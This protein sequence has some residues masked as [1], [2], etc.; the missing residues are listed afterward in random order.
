MKNIIILLFC[1]ICNFTC[2]LSQSK[3]VNEVLKLAPGEGYIYTVNINNLNNLLTP[4]DL[5]KWA[6][7]NSDKY[8]LVSYNSK[9][10][11]AYGKEYSLINSFSFI[12]IQDL[13]QYNEAM[14][15]KAIAL[16]QRA[17][18]RAAADYLITT[19]ALGFLFQNAI[20]TI[21]A[22]REIDYSSGGSSSYSSS[23]H[24]EN[25]NYGNSNKQNKSISTSTESTTDIKC[26]DIVF[27]YMGDVPVNSH[28]SRPYY[29][30]CDKNGNVLYSQSG[31]K[32]PELIDASG[33]DLDI[34]G[35]KYAQGYYTKTLGSL[36]FKGKTQL[37]VKINLTGC[38]Q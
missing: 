31:E 2:I 35:N 14:R 24:A 19:V 26:E 36:Y 7:K 28:D 8:V 21:K 38:K 32:Y 3:Y 27:K 1:L 33:A 16:A 30:L 5:L 17:Q 13:Q 11:W 20:S 9:R 29:V 12:K 22:E 4:D 10:E 25:N 6:N 15:Q 34:F 18:E 37:E 23:N